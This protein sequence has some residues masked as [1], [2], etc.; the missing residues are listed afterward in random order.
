MSLHRSLFSGIV[1]CWDSARWEWS[2]PNSSDTA[3]AS[4][5]RR[6][7]AAWGHAPIAQ[8]GGFVH[9]FELENNTNHTGPF[10]ND[11]SVRPVGCG[12]VVRG[13]P[14]GAPLEARRFVSGEAVRLAMSRGPP[15]LQRP[16]L[17]AGW[18]WRSFSCLAKAAQR[19][20]AE[21]RPQVSGPCAQRGHTRDRGQASWNQSSVRLSCALWGMLF[22][23]ELK[24]RAVAWELKALRGQERFQSPPSSLSPLCNIWE[25]WG[26]R[27]WDVLKL[28]QLAAYQITLWSY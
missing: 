11:H 26:Q 27:W 6:M 2:S 22:S 8:Q 21:Q 28:T 24:E 19:S 15:P 5:S 7:G 9:I 16:S 17:T 4:A 12:Q 13:P 18:C 14:Q 3:W 10:W 1:G 23:T 20:R 25:N